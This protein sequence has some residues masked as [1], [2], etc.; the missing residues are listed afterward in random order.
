M[1]DAAVRDQA[2]LI[3]GLAVVQAGTGGVLAGEMPPDPRLTRDAGGTVTTTSRSGWI[4]TRRRLARGDLRSVYARSPPGRRATAG[5]SMASTERLGM[6]Q[7][8]WAA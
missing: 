5:V 3:E 6:G 1:R 7:S 2:A 4:V 8:M